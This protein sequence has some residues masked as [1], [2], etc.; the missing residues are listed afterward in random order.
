MKIEG[1]KIDQ[2]LIHFIKQNFNGIIIRDERDYWNEKD[3]IIK[4]GTVIGICLY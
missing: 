2:C 4:R 3:R 1:N